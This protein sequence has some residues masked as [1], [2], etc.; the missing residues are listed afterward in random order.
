MQRY[1]DFVLNMY[2][3]IADSFSNHAGVTVKSINTMSLAE[4]CNHLEQ[5][6][7]RYR[8]A[9]MSGEDTGYLEEFA[10]KLGSIQCAIANQEG[11]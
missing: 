8:E 7:K 1:V 11:Q 9:E 4:L 5:E 10:S 2:N 6:E 3:I